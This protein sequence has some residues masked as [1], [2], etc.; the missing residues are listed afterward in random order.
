MCARPEEGREI[1]TDTRKIMNARPNF[2]RR[3]FLKL[4]TGAAGG[5]VVCTT[6]PGAGNTGGAEARDAA[7]RWLPGTYVGVLPGNNFVVRLSRPEMGQGTLTSMPMLIAE[8]MDLDWSRVTIEWAPVAPPFD[9]PGFYGVEW[10]SAVRDMFLPLRQLGAGLRLLLI[11]AAARRWG[12]DPQRCITSAGTVMGP[13]P[14]HRLRYSEL[15]GDLDGQTLPADPPLKAAADYRLLG[16][17]QK[18]RITGDVINGRAEFGLDT[19][20]RDALVALVIRP[21]NTHSRPA[22]FD[23][24]AAN[25]MPGVK[26]IVEIPAG[27][28]V[29]ADTFWRARKARDAV[30]VDWK[31]A[32]DANWSSDSI[33]T[34]LSQ[35]LDGAATFVPLEDLD[36]GARLSA[37]PAAVRR[38][39]EVP[40]QAHAAIEPTSCIA[41]V[42][43]DTCEL[44]MGTQNPPHV[45]KKVAQVLGIAEDRIVFHPKLMGGSFGRKYE[46][47]PAVDAALLSKL[48]GKPVNC[49]WLREDE[50]QNGPHRPVQMGRIAATLNADGLPEAM[51]I[52]MAGPSYF[53]KQPSDLDRVRDRGYG[54]DTSTFEGICPLIYPLSKLR[55]A[56][57]WVDFGITIGSWR[58]TSHSMNTFFLESF[59]D[60]LAAAAKQDA[61]DY[62]LRWLRE[63][64]AFPRERVPKNA[65]AP[66]FETE[67][68]VR[69]MERVRTISRWDKRRAAGT[70]LGFAIQLAFEGYA[71]LAAEV[72]VSADSFKVNG[73][74]MVADLGQVVNPNS[75]D[76]QLR[77]GLIFGLTAAIK[78]G[79]TVRDGR[80]E[81]ANFNDFEVLRMSEVPDIVVDLIESHATPA[82]VGEAGVPLAAPAVANAICAAGGPRLREL[83][84]RMKAS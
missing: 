40:Y 5:L 10:S 54:L 49:I 31:P 70:G 13:E 63:G 25:K 20:I 74:W 80:I 34:H 67:R 15:T 61:V 3:R 48:L 8:E 64:Q 16:K 1:G 58:S 28:A 12:V 52:R 45:R 77:G 4:V 72:T 38:T 53:I 24:D 82:G 43:G 62:R 83:P 79:L 76:Q 29:V 68:M 56:Q 42:K 47:D 57:H 66:P 36:V 55:L 81:Q 41:H 35:R 50:M 69:V 9:N 14:K 18:S 17:A 27:V 60:E 59:V 46:P 26:A 21:P 7:S 6:G 84:L 51:E 44:W 75:V 32:D 78:S 37:D 73:L 2:S 30:K 39:Y 19:R 22:H 71:A 33:R 11:R 23:A 65:L